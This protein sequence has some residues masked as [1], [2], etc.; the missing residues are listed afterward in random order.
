MEDYS[1]LIEYGQLVIPLFSGLLG[2][3]ITFKALQKKF[4]A[5]ANRANAEAGSILVG[6]SLE[7]VE[8]LQKSI[9]AH[10]NKIDKL[11]L[12]VKKLQKKEGEH[13]KERESLA[14]EIEE[15][16]DENLRLRILDGNKSKQ[17]IELEQ[18]I[19]KLQIQL[20]EYVTN[21]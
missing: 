5:D 19:L 8:A 9:N 13:N 7:M 10:E 15:L 20:K 2:G 18:K 4:K 14:K 17:I 21:I 11:I 1:T 6:A 3:V 12:Q 16:K